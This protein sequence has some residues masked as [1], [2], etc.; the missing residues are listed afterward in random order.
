MLLQRALFFLGKVLGLFG[1]ML[2]GLAG[3]AYISNF[4]F[5]SDLSP[6]QLP[7]VIALCI[8]CIVVGFVGS[9]TLVVLPLHFHC[10]KA[11]KL[12]SWE[13]RD[14]PQLFRL[15]QWYGRQLQEYGERRERGEP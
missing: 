8:V 10:S 13:S 12:F 14:P 2:L 3:A 6:W 9:L 7:L 5:G 11:R 4:L 1:G 15:Y